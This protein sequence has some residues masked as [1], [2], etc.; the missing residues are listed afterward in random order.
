[1]QAEI[2]SSFELKPEKNGI[3]EIARHDMKN[4][5]LVIGIYLCRLPIA[6]ISLV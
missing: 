5:A 4:V 1:M 6:D 3:P 2:I